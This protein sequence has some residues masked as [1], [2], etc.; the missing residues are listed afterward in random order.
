M[1]TLLALALTCTLLVPAHAQTFSTADVLAVIELRDHIQDRVKRQVKEMA[2]RLL[3]ENARFI[4]SL[5][6]Q[7]RDLEDEVK[8][9]NSEYADLYKQLSE[10]RAVA[11]AID[12]RILRSGGTCP[13]IQVATSFVS[14]SMKGQRQ[15]LV[16]LPQD[17]VAS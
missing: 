4:H 15:F 1:N 3:G 10:V 7:I 5:Q 14:S 9:R 11:P 12:E 13:N 17:S 2:E 8:K 6:E 16:C